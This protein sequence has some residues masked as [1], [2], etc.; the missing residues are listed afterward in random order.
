[1]VNLAF[2][3]LQLAGSPKLLETRIEKMTKLNGFLGIYFKHLE[4][5]KLLFYSFNLLNQ[6]VYKFFL[7]IKTIYNWD[8]KTVAPSTV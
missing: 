8:F 2:F 4:T 3:S 7:A 6:P 1:M 5:F